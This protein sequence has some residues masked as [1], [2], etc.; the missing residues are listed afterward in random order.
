MDGNRY[1]IGPPY[2][3]SGEISWSSDQKGYH[4]PPTLHT[5]PHQSAQ[6]HTIR[7]CHIQDQLLSLA[8]SKGD[9]SI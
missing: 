8:Q 2:C 9:R 4:G 6:L 5:V 3:S 7:A 1:L